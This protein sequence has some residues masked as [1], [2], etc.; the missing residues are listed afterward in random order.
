MKGLRI[1]GTFLAGAGV[2]PPFYNVINP[3]VLHYL[4]SPSFI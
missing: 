2:P 3:T 1:S 4:F